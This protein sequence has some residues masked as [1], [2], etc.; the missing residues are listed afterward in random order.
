MTRKRLE[1]IGPPPMPQEQRVID[2]A[3]RLDAAYKKNRARF[4]AIKEQIERHLKVTARPLSG[5]AEYQTKGAL[6]FTKCPN[7]KDDKVVRFVL[8]TRKKAFEE[9]CYLLCSSPQRLRSAL[10]PTLL[11]SAEIGD[12]LDIHSIGCR[13]EFG[14]ESHR[15]QLL[16]IF[17]ETPFFV[18]A[19]D[20]ESAEIL[21]ATPIHNYD[22]LSQK[23]RTLKLECYSHSKKRLKSVKEIASSLRRTQTVLLKWKLAEDKDA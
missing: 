16:A 21:F 2:A 22:A 23:I 8:A 11:A 14:F 10:H 13:H 18:I 5:I 20:M 9:G 15:A 4:T 1:R 19:I 12:L 7:G 6:L 17:K 3:A